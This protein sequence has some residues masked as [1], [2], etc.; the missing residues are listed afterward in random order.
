ALLTLW[1]ERGRPL[2]I[3]GEAQIRTAEVTSFGFPSIN[4]A[5]AFA[6]ATTLSPFVAKRTGTFLWLAAFLAAFAQLYAGS[7]LPLDVIGGM[8]L[9]VLIGS[10]I[11]YV[12]GSPNYSRSH[13]HVRDA[14]SLAHI[15]VA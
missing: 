2:E 3:L 11:R 8:A 13:E 12:F 7:N 5:I 1:V 15:K 9:G 6:V 10:V 14:L 4:S